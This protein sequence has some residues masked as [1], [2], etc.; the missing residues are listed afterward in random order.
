MITKS[1]PP[2]PFRP[3]RKPRWR[4]PLILVLTDR[5]YG[6]KRGFSGPR[7]GRDRSV[8]GCHPATPRASRPAGNAG[9]PRDR[10]PSRDDRSRIRVRYPCLAYET[11]TGRI[12][13]SAITDRPARHGSARLPERLEPGTKKSPRPPR[14][15]TS[16]ARTRVELIRHGPEFRPVSRRASTQLGTLLSS[17]ISGVSPGRSHFDRS[18]TKT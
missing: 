6:P 7:R 9:F 11:T 15:W 12:P 4:L 17:R 14:R 16:V 3:E 5:R 13:D 2:V 1:G 8:Q 18:T 10:A